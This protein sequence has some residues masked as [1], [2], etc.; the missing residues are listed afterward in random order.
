MAPAGPPDHLE[1]SHSRPLSHRDWAGRQLSSA[2]GH[3]T[4]S[5]HKERFVCFVYFSKGW[6]RANAFSNLEGFV[7]MCKSRH[8]RGFKE[9]TKRGGVST[10]QRPYP[11]GDRNGTVGK[12][13]PALEAFKIWPANSLPSGQQREC[14]GTT[15]GKDI[16]LVASGSCS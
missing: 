9:E 12:Q 16:H 15:C 1:N 13:F 11:V 6:A 10:Q 3:P 14:A 5:R 7:R 8:E 4:A 2:F